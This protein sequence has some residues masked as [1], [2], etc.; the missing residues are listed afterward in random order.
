MSL[1]QLEHQ[2]KVT[3]QNGVRTAPQHAAAAAVHTERSAATVQAQRRTPRRLRQP[4]LW[5][6]SMLVLTAFIGAVLLWE[7]HRPKV[8]SVIEPTV[9]TITESLA[10]TGRVSG[11]TETSVGA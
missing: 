1:Q 9:A 3:P 6:V 5:R 7:L 4:G 10:A 11:T 8:V 2:V